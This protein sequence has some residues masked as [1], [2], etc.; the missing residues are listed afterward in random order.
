MVHHV[1][2]TTQH[3]YCDC[4]H[5]GNTKCNEDELRE[6][7]DRSTAQV[8]TGAGRTIGSTGPGTTT[9]QPVSV[10]GQP[11]APRASHRADFRSL[12]KGF[13]FFLHS[14]SNFILTRSGCWQS[15]RRS[16]LRF[17]PPTTTDLLC[18]K[19]PR[20][21][22]YLKCYLI[23]AT[24]IVPHLVM[25]YIHTQKP[26][27]QVAVDLADNGQKNMVKTIS[28]QRF[29]KTCQWFTWS[30]QIYF[31]QHIERHKETF[32]NVSKFWNIAF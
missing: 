22:S 29:N 17:S 1:T 30:G 28:M 8:S 4:C 3:S 12:F 7:G 32:W 31:L 10:D 14:R 24:S 5:G 9:M 13:F 26:L 18:I 2:A 20:R 21:R 16:T 15:E 27:M 11:S 23:V 25:K 6:D 19:T